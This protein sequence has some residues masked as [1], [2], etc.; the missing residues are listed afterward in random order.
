VAAVGGTPELLTGKITASSNARVRKI[1]AAIKM[2][3]SR[4]R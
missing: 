1:K 3:V 4:V 2:I